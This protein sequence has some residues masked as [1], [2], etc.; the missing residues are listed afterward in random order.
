M[1]DQPFDKF[2]DPFRP[3]TVPCE[4]HCLHCHQQYESWQIEWR[5]LPDS[6]IS[7]TWCCPTAGCDGVGFGFDILPVDPQW[8][9]ENG[10]RMYHSDG[11]GFDDDEDDDFDDEPFDLDDSEL[12]PASVDEFDADAFWIDLDIIR[13]KAHGNTPQP[14]Y[15]I[16]PPPKTH[17]PSDDFDEDDIPF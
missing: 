9:D 6:P 10:E 4:V 2:S 7:G 11:E 14:P 3:P 8:T 5:D 1:A 16:A 17:K 13:P 15:D 12:D